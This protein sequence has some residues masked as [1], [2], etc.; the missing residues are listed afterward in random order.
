MVLG[1]VVIGASAS[2]VLA[3]S[4]RTR[5]TYVSDAITAAVHENDGTLLGYG[6]AAS[7]AFDAGDLAGAMTGSVFLNLKGDSQSF[8][9]NGGSGFPT[10]VKVVATGIGTSTYT[11]TLANPWRPHVYGSMVDLGH[12]VFGTLNLPTS[13]WRGAG[14]LKVTVTSVSTNTYLTLPADGVVIG[15]TEIAP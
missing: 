2:A 3:G 7:F 10:T 12:G 14:T 13:V 11:T 6:A 8:G 1:L 9:M 5:A 15:Y 4:S